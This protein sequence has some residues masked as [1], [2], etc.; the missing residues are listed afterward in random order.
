MTRPRSATI[1]AG[2]HAGVERVLAW[3]A[4]AGVAVLGLAIVMVVGDIAA[5]AVL[6]RSLTG[7]VDITQLCVMTMAFLAIPYTFIRNAHVG[8]TAATDWLP[9]R[10]RAGFD[11]L[12]ALAGAALVALLGRYGLDQALLA[13][14]YGDSSQTIGIPMI[15]YWSA[16]LGGCLLSLVATLAEALRRFV[17]AATGEAP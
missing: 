6:N 17:H 7:L 3:A 12:A 14:R 16:L 8:I 1:A 4:T 5:R 10:A 2:L 15:W 11:A 9:E 13:L